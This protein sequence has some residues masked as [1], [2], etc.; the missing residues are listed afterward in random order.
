MDERAELV[1]VVGPP[2][3]VRVVQQRR[4]LGREGVGHEVGAEL[5]LEVGEQQREVAPGGLARGVDVDTG[6]NVC[7]GARSRPVRDGEGGPGCRH[8]HRPV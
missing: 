3:G 8:D 1:G 4:V 2:A 7:P 5:L 6:A